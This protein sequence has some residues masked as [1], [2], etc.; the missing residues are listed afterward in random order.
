MILGLLA[1][2][3]AAAWTHTGF[4]WDQNEFPLDWYMS[5]YIEDS[6]PQEAIYGDKKNLYYQEEALVRAFGAWV[7]EAPCASLDATYGGMLEGVHFGTQNEGTR[8]MY[9]DDPAGQLGTGV[10]GLTVS[11]GSGTVAF[12]V[13]G[14]TYVYFGDADIIFNDNIAWGTS[15]EIDGGQCNSTTSIQSVATHEV[16]HLFGMDHSCEEDDI[17]GDNELLLATMYWSSGQCTTHQNTLEGDDVEGI[18]ALYG[19]FATFESPS[20]RRG[21]V[22]LEVAFE[23]ATND[24]KI[25]NI[26]WSFGDGESSTELEPVHTYTEPGQYT[27]SATIGGQTAECGDWSFT[28]RERAYVVACGEPEPGIDTEGKPYGEL[29]TIEH[30]NGLVYQLVNQADTSVYGCVESIDWQVLKG[31]EVVSES[32][33]WSP[34]IEFP[35]EGNYTIHL[36]IGGPGGATSEDLE[37]TAEDKVGEDFKGGGCATSGMGSA[38]LALSGLAFGFAALRR[39]RV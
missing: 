26:E 21:G 17:C 7:N 20:E 38:G 18:T 28:Q 9:Y 29:F 30:Y 16:G 6:L 14:T 23:L 19:P 34:K 24:A 25:G 37:V 33:A 1:V 36:E 5:D 3:T 10:L 11:Y 35:S 4:V 22:P 12:S 31:D 39:R 32:S 15:E 13:G 8:L 2:Q 27:V